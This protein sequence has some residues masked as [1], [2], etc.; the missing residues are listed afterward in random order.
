[1]RDFRAGDL[2]GM[3]AADWTQ[4]VKPWLVL[5][6]VSIFFF[7]VRWSRKAFIGVAVGIGAALAATNPDWRGIVL[8][9]LETAAFIGAFFAAL[10]TLRNVA[11]TSPRFRPPG[12]SWPGNRRV[13]AMPP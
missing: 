9:G 2:Q 1:M 12:R 4:Y 7:Q 11:Q 5:A 6:L 10:S 3:G 13:A 8:R